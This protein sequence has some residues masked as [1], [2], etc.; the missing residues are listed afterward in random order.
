MGNRRWELGIGK[1]F[2]VVTDPTSSQTI[3]HQRS[4]LNSYRFPISQFLFPFAHCLLPS[5][6]TRSAVQLI[7][8]HDD[9]RR[10]WLAQTISQVGSQISYLAVPLTAAVTLD[11]TPFEM[12]LLTATGSLPSLIT[13][14]F[15]GVLVDRRAR[16]PV[17]ISADLARAVLLGV[18]P[19]AWLLG[20]RFRHGSV[21]SDSGRVAR[22]C[23]W[24]AAHAGS[25]C[26]PGSNTCCLG[27]AIV[28][29][30]AARP[31]T[32]ARGLDYLPILSNSL[33]KQPQV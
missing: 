21:R 24:I 11:A 14:L 31:R 29:L 4:T 16:R 5:A 22:G 1:W 17:L 26:Y 19:A 20:A 23:A 12:G 13:G 6:R 28:A 2:A 15:A 7:R 8:E 27:L 33:P 25:R 9:F 18:I 30:V 10:L 32:R 3:D